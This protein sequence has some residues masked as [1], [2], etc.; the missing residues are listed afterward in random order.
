MVGLVAQAFE[1]R[2]GVQSVARWFAEELPR[3][4]FDVVVFE[5]AFSAHDRGS[6]RLLRP[7]TWAKR[8]VS[9]AGMGGQVW[10]VGANA[11]ELEPFRYLPRRELT[12]RLRSCE[13]LQ[14]VAGTPAVALV[15][16]GAGRPTFVHMA[17][18]VSLE[19]PSVVRHFGTLQRAW[20]RATMKVVTR[21]ERAALGSV[22]RTFVMSSDMQNHLAAC[23]IDTV[24]A[25]PGVDTE[26]FRPT[27]AW[28][29]DGY[30]LSVGRLS[31]SRKGYERM[32]QALA[33]LRDY[34]E[35]P[36][37]LV[38][39][40]AGTLPG[41]VMRLAQELDVDHLLDVRPDVS[42]EDLVNLYQGAS[43][44]WS[45]SF[46]EGLGLSLVEALACGVPV[47]ATETAG[48]NITVTGDVG[49]LLS[50]GSDVSREVAHATARILNGE[51]A[52]MSMAARERAVRRFSAEAAIV[53]FVEA[54]R[55]AL[56]TVP[57]ASV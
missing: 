39:A 23:G 34:R 51:G 5:L 14:V 47:V 19:R 41:G 1:G 25:P 46:E 35:P 54:Y 4:E 40:G 11:V 20:G 57:G 56:D 44:Y 18:L 6:R 45:T 21:M 37:R 48:T 9:P 27:V 53:P 36:L 12:A 7:T 15:T 32:V 8:L 17:T 33:F 38:L 2:G 13:V 43:V 42:S 22:R 24:L 29:P 28:S 52:R 49:I 50:Q 3:N 16:R 30:V 10:K 26:H 55:E 31:E